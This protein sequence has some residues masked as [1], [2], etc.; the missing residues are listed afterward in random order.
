MQAVMALSQKLDVLSNQL[1]NLA[2]RTDELYWERLLAGDQSQ[3]LL[4]KLADEALGEIEAGQARWGSGL[5][6]GTQVYLDG[7]GLGDN[8]GCRRFKTLACPGLNPLMRVLHKSPTAGH[9]AGPG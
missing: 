8:G 1:T 3:Q 9:W 4:E 7:V 5:S 6:G 2:E